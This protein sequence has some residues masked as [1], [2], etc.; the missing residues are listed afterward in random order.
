[1]TDDIAR[2]RSA[3]PMEPQASDDDPPVIQII[4]GELHRAV[5]ELEQ[6]LAKCGVYQHARRLVLVRCESTDGRGIH[7]PDAGPLLHQLDPVSLQDYAGRFVN[8]EKWDGR[9]GDYRRRDCPMSYTKALLQRGSWPSVPRLAGIIESPIVTPNGGVIDDPG[10]DTFTGLYLASS[11]PLP[12]YH[13]PADAPSTDDV[14]WARE[15]LLDVIGTFP[16]VDDPDRSATLAAILGALH[17]RLFPSAPISVV[18]APT[19]GTGKS[20]LCDLVAV[21]ALGRRGTAL[22]LGDDEAETDKR[23]V[24]VLL[25]GDPFVIIDNASRAIAGDS[26]CQLATQPTIR[27]RVLG[28]STMVTLP[29]SAAILINGNNLQIIG[30]VRR[31]SK[32]IRLDAGVERPESIPH[33]GDILTEVAARRGEIITAALTLVR[34]YLAAGS[35]DV[36]APPLG[37]FSEWDRMVRRPLIWAG[38][39]DPMD[40]SHGLRESDPD[41]EA[42]RALLATWRVS[43]G[44]RWIT[45][46]QVASDATSITPRFDNG[47]PTPDVPDLSAALQVITAEKITARRIGNWL[48]RHRDRL[49]DGLRLERGPDDPAT[50]VATWRVVQV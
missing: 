36:D 31:R 44:D 45:A 48:R 21:I 20:L 3:P 40:A 14:Q 29:T 24:G 37:G 4:D 5:D 18:T 19:P 30:D 49:V 41:L 50:K 27:R 32:L 12:G 1:M 11:T 28:V 10:Y 7:R 35:P 8:F 42:T 26:L 2:L 34:A 9:A 6:H 38:L 23:I 39:A 33:R 47:C 15:L 16:L 13:R 25:A 17:R 46:A 43:Y 22:S